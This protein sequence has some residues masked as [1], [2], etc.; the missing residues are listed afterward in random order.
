[1]YSRIRSGFALRGTPN[2]SPALCL[3]L[4]L[5][6]ELS[7]R[8][9]SIVLVKLK[10]GPYGPFCNLMGRVTR[11]ELATFGTTNQRSNQLSYTRQTFRVCA[12][13][14]F[15][16]LRQGFGG[17]SIFLIVRSARNNENRW[18]S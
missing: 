13:F 18:W 15:A 5:V 6:V 14:L 7:V 11:F 16:R 9:W 1:M 17:H 4:L 10:N 12:L 2:K 3:A 8:I